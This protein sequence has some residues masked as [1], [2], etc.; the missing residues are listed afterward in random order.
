L[1]PERP[2]L[3]WS[4][5]EAGYPQIA[6]ISQIPVSFRD[7]RGIRGPKVAGFTEPRRWWLTPISKNADPCE[8]LLH[9]EWREWCLKYP[10]VCG[11][12]GHRMV[13][14]QDAEPRNWPRPFV[15]QE[16]IRMDRPEVYRIYCAGQ[17]GSGLSW[18]SAPTDSSTTLIG[19]WATPDLRARYSAASPRRSG[20]RPKCKDASPLRPRSLIGSNGAV[21]RVPSPGA[22]I[23]DRRR[24][25]DRQFIAAK[26]PFRRGSR[27]RVSQSRCGAWNA[28]R[29]A[30]KSA[31]KDRMA[32]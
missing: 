15:V 13:S 23:E 17:L 28:S 27:L 16:F 26:H 9:L 32:G 8:R 4:S 12:S 6:P 18:K 20:G 10:T 29:E 22:C 24:A 31:K 25:V 11:A 30:A 19:T 14:A 5:P 2:R 1:H 21:G 3:R 7:V